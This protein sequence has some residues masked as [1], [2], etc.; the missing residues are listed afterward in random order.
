MILMVDDTPEDIFTR[1]TLPELHSYPTATAESGG[2]GVEKSIKKILRISEW[3]NRLR[4][5]TH[6][7]EF[8]LHHF[9]KRH[10]KIKFLNFVQ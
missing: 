10:F 9:D 7:P 4:Y 2:R 5:Q 8:G 1:R 6:Q 3:R